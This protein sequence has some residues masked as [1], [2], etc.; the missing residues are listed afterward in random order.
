M[1]R[2]IALRKTDSFPRGRNGFFITSQ[3][4]QT[5]PP[6][7]ISFREIR[8]EFGGFGKAGESFFAFFVAPRKLAQ[9]I[10][11][12]GILRIDLDFLQEFLL[13]AFPGFRARIR[14]LEQQ[15]AKQKMHAGRV[16]FLLDDAFVFQL[17]GFPA[18]L[19]FKGF[20]VQFVGGKRLRGGASQILGRARG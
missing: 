4:D 11:R 18:P 7:L 16:G 15:P 2:G 1:R 20:G 3:G 14:F 13:R 10:L 17:S 12:A 6:A 19:H 5:S 8:I 9:N